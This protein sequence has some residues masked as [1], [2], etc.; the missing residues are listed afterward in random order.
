MK[1]LLLIIAPVLVIAFS[2]TSCDKEPTTTVP[3]I[4]TPDVVDTPDNNN[5]PAPITPTT[6]DGIWGTLVALKMEYSYSSPQIPFP[7]TTMSELGVAAFYDDDNGKANLVDAGKV[8]VNSY[9]LEKQTNNS[10]TLTATTGL[11]PSS[12]DLGSSVKWEVAGG[13]GIPMIN[14]SHTG[15]FPAYTGTIPSEISKSGGLEIE[16][17]S[18]VTGADS[19]YIVIVTSKETIIKRYG[20]SPGPSKANIEASELSSLPNVDDNTAYLEVVPFTYKLN[21]VNGKRFAFVKET[22][23]VS[24]VNIK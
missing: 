14:Y 1:K 18:K 16:L 2:L 11:T 9:E 10:Y 6:A 21:T 4:D 15:S 22:A 8:M 5:G 17:G 23:V 3:T 19:V 12:L 13:S 7:V 20:A 24:S